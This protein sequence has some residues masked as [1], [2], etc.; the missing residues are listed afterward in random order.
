MI[1]NPVGFLTR[2]VLWLY[3]AGAWPLIGCNRSLWLGVRDGPYYV[4]AAPVLD[5]NRFP[6]R[7][8]TCD[9][10][11]SDFA[12]ALLNGGLVDTLVLAAKVI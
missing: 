10:N 1:D 6:G 12:D 2:R 3:A 5:L 9:M 7:G 4:D 11:A 8:G